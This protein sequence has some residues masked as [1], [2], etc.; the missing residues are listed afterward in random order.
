MKLKSTSKAFNDAPN[1][2]LFVMK[3]FPEHVY[4]K[5]DKFT[6]LQLEYHHLLPADVFYDS[7]DIRVL[8]DPRMDEDQYDYMRDQELHWKMT[9]PGGV[10]TAKVF[11]SLE[12][13]TVK[14]TKPLKKVSGQ[15]YDD[16]SLYY[17]DPWV[18]GVWTS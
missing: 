6:V 13:E 7:D 18:D 15:Y 1:G 12:P 17:D 8:G 3:L 4:M 9:H 2:A 11:P 16:P 10:L 14:K 5:V